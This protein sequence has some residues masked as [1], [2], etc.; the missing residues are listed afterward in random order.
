M[1]AILDPARIRRCGVPGLTSIR[2]ATLLRHPVTGAAL[3]ASFGG[4]RP[5]ILGKGL[6]FVRGCYGV[7][8]AGT[9]P[10]P[11]QL[12]RARRWMLRADVQ[13]SSLMARRIR[14]LVSIN[15]L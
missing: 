12:K 6:A 9:V 1:G 5:G 13:G 14:V 2:D 8:F 3:I 15:A 11:S 4:F 7:V 10:E